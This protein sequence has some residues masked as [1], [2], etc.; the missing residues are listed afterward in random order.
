[1]Q[2]SEAAFWG[3]RAQMVESQHTVQP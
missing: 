2:G 1:L 3:V